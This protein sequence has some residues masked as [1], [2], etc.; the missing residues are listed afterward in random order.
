[1]SQIV[2]RLER[3]GK[4]GLL[5]TYALIGGFAVSAWGVSRAAEDID[6]AVVLGISAP[7]VLAAH[8]G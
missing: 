2:T 6:L 3:A 5:Q 7:S 8:L 1:M 4:N